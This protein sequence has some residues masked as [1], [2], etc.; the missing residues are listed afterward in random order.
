MLRGQT[1]GGEPDSRS[2]AVV[3]QRG[4]YRVFQG[5][6]RRFPVPIAQS[7]KALRRFHRDAARHRAVVRHIPHSPLFRA[8]VYPLLLLRRYAQVSVV[9]PPF[10]FVHV[11]APFHARGVAARCRGLAAFWLCPID[12]ILQETCNFVKMLCCFSF[13][14]TTP[15]ILREAYADSP[16]RCASP[17]GRAKSRPPLSEGLSSLLKA[18]RK[19]RCF[20]WKQRFFLAFC[21]A[22][23]YNS[24]APHHRKRRTTP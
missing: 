5:A 19:K 14:A 8:A 22:Q 16:A 13:A 1:K 12:T 4:F 21:E 3:T 2:P 6:I 7:L 23:A 24:C 20:Q 17:S 9:P 10:F 15:C 11:S 18:H